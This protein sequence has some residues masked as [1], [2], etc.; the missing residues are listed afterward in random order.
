MRVF[1][2]KRTS[3]HYLSTSALIN[4]S[5]IGSYEWKCRHALG[6][7]P[8]EELYRTGMTRM[9]KTRPPSANRSLQ[10]A[11]K[12]L[13][14]GYCT[15]NVTFRTSYRFSHQNGP[16]LIADSENSRVLQKTIHRQACF[17][18]GWFAGQTT[19]KAGFGQS[20]VCPFYILM[21]KVWHVWS[22]FTFV[23]SSVWKNLTIETT[24]RVLVAFATRIVV[25]GLVVNPTTSRTLVITSTSS[26]VYY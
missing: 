6:M 22:T 4:Y 19:G 14:C 11:K 24:L 15:F 9:S 1:S 2:P 25:V 17:M 18:I 3:T 20:R 26:I 16:F 5:K 23:R 8:W 13:F 12:N 7:R 21:W 10:M